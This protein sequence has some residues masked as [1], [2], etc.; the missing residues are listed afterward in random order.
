[1]TVSNFGEF[2]FEQDIDQIVQKSV[3]EYFK[4]R[5][6]KPVKILIHGPPSCG[7]TTLAKALSCY[8]AAYYIN[9]DEI[10]EDAL[11]RL[12]SSICKWI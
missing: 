10:L 11:I 4:A 5:S 7:K 1:M 9:P 2:E 6:I 3:Q 12:V 8:Y